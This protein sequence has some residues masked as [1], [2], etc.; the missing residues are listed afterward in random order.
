MLRS[1]FAAVENRSFWK[2]TE[3]AGGLDPIRQKMAQGISAATA[4]RAPPPPPMR[5]LA[6]AFSPKRGHQSVVVCTIGE[7][8]SHTVLR[9]FST[10][11]MA[12]TN[13]SG[14]DQDAP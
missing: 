11:F 5:S 13:S 9:P 3:P 14:V 2:S 12:I 1:G 7:T 8:P 4:P 10:A 6:A